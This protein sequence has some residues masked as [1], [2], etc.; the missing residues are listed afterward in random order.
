MPRFPKGVTKISQLEIDVSK[1]W[2]GK[3]IQ[4]IG[5]PDTDNDVARRDTIDSKIAAHETG[6]KHRWTLGKLLKGAGPG[7]NPTEIDVP[8]TFPEA[9]AGD[10]LETSADTPRY[11]NSLSYTKLKE[12]KVGRNGT[13]RIKFAHKCVAG[14]TAYG[15][16]YRN[17][18][19]VGTE[20]TTTS[21]SYV[22]KSQDIPNWV[23]GDL[24]QLYSKTT[25][26]GY[27]DDNQN[28]RIY[29]NAPIVNTVIIN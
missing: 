12:I 28:F 15:R 3:K 23:R 16:V 17:G 7:S 14:A 27:H 18:I 5:V 25:I 6:G 9:S 10:T 8:A 21:E 4:S 24:C 20:Q 2:A 13:Y 26:V 11:S 29:A 22:T 1:D 19:P